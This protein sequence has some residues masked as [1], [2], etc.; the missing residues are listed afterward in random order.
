MCIIKGGFSWKFEKNVLRKSYF[1]ENRRFLTKYGHASYFFFRDWTFFGR[2]QWFFREKSW[3]K[4]ILWTF[5]AHNIIYSSF[6]RIGVF[7]IN[8]GHDNRGFSWKSWKKLLESTNQWSQEHC[9][10]IKKQNTLIMGLIEENWVRHPYVGKTW[11]T[12][13]D[14]F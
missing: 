13:C 12:F 5:L 4:G 9:E 6:N 7:L 11:S 10:L 2:E 14:F 1:W 3:K 8:Y